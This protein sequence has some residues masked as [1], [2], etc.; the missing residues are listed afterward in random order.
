M[1]ESVP[2]CVGI[3]LDGNRRWA[4]AKGLP[5]LEGHR[6]GLGKIKETARFVSKRGVSHLALYMFSTENWNREAAEVAYLMDLFRGLIRKEI[7]ELKEE[8]VRVRFVGQR[9]RFSEDLQ[10][11]MKDVEAQTALNTGLTLWCCLSYGGRAEIV[12]AA[13]AGAG[14][15][16]LTEDALANHLWTV[17][18]PDPDIIIRTSGEKRLSGFLTWQSVY[19]ELF[20]ID[21]HWPDFSEEI[22]DNILTEYK[23][24]ERRHGK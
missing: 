13:R 11:A 7:R 22:F 16:N 1:N 19:S 8:N 4:K 10:L 3:I 9:E 14:A 12:A 23:E 6:V 5:T 17:G 18:M 20:F 15:G 21:S 2:Q 24:R